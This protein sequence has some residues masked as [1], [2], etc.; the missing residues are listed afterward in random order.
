M[1][2]SFAMT[3]A[4]VLQS[5]VYKAGPWYNEPLG[6]NTPNHVHVCWQIPAYV[7]ISFSEIFA[8]ITGLEYAYSKAPA[9]MKSF[10]MS[11]FLLTNAFGSAI[12][13]ALSP[14]TVD[15]KFTWLFTGL[16]VAC[17]I[18]GCLFWLCF[19]KYND[20]EEEMNAM[21]YEEEDE[22]DLNPISAPKANDIEISEPM[23][24]LRS[25][26]KY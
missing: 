13:C 5:F 20:T 18:S 6:H 21:D 2:G 1:F 26:A 19:R 3:W 17:F 12:G 16:A 11:I 15:P 8:S 25:T 9:S 10:I 23:D 24:S 4:A 22:F 7:L 14:V